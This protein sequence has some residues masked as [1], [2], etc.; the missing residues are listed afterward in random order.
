[1]FGLSHEQLKS[2]REKFSE[3][4]GLEPVKISNKISITEQSTT[5]T[6]PKSHYQPDALPAKKTLIIELHDAQGRLMKIHAT[7]DCV[8]EL[9][10]TLYPSLTFFP[11][12]NLKID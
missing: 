1:M 4:L 12:K 7:T 2:K 9:V 8:Q 6:K 10:S 3:S 5:V 11:Q